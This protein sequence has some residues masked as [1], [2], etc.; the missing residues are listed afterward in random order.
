M[1]DDEIEFKTAEELLDYL[2]DLQKPEKDS[3]TSW[4]F[5][6][7]GCKPNQRSFCQP[8]AWRS[9]AG[10]QRYWQTNMGALTFN[11]AKKHIMQVDTKEFP[12][13]SQWLYCLFFE[14]HSLYKFLQKANEQGICSDF[15]S[16]LAPLIQSHKNQF[17]DGHACIDE[18]IIDNLGLEIKSWISA[19]NQQLH[20][21]QDGKPS[22]INAVVP[23]VLAQ[24]YGMSTRLL[25]FSKDYKVAAFF[26][27]DLSSTICQP[28]Q[29]ALANE[30]AK[31]DIIIYA[32]SN[33]LAYACDATANDSM[34]SKKIF[35][36]IC[37]E[38][39]ADLSY[40]IYLNRQRGVFLSF[41]LGDYQFLKTGS[42][43]SVESEIAKIEPQYLPG[44]KISEV[45]KKFRLPSN[46]R[47]NLLY[48]LMHQGIDGNY[49]RP[50][51]ERIASDLMRGL[52][53]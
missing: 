12:H 44:G 43:P 42:W 51:L 7:Q 50:S 23:M 29:C 35:S 33:W 19:T 24:H 49:L 17:S 48:L 25:D 34:S 52:Q 20:L 39:I 16:L 18:S 2:Y 11:S 3:I 6:G 46:Q 10:L 41:R 27:A 4:V 40:N 32:I 13:I 38:K 14:H 8:R 47:E 37:P 31:K 30:N 26:A 15:Y 5:R 1:F 53:G 9:L 28:E 21:A 36:I 45:Y 22:D